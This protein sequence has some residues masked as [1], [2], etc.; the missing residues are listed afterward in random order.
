LGAQ[1][2]KEKLGESS[3]PR[4]WNRQEVIPWEF[5]VE[6]L[7]PYELFFFICLKGLMARHKNVRVWGEWMNGKKGM[8]VAKMFEDFGTKNGLKCD[9]QHQPTLLPVNL[10]NTPPPHLGPP[11]PF[12]FVSN[13]PQFWQIF[14]SRGNA[15]IGV[16]RK[17]VVH[18]FIQLFLLMGFFVVELN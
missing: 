15:Q 5:I 17:F 18:P 6:V 7:W 11:H 12:W 2:G 8:E 4:R 14:F 3:G 9:G 13:F 1:I 16:N 10:S